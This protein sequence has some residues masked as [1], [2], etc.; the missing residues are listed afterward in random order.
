MITILANV[1]NVG[2]AL[3]M[4]QAYP[5]DPNNQYLLGWNPTSQA[6][7]YVPYVGNTFGDFSAVRDLMSGRDT[8]VGEDLSVAGTA[9]IVGATTIGGTLGVTG[10]ATFTDRAQFPGGTGAFSSN[11]SLTAV[12]HIASN[13]VSSSALAFDQLGI[14]LNKVVGARVTGWQ[15]ATGTATRTTFDTATVTLPLLAQR[16]KALI[17]DLIT[18]GLIGT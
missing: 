12:S 14:G 2:F 7:D 10:I 3:P 18:H 15:A 6:L 1:G 17:D 4:V 8:I 16:M 11:G 13:G 9:S 5:V